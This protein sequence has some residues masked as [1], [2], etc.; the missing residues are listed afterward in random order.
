MTTETFHTVDADSPPAPAYDRSVSMARANVLALLVIPVVAAFVLVPFALLHGTGALGGAWN[1][2][3]APWMFIPFVLISIVVHE[4]LHGVGFLAAGAP[5]SSLKFGVQVRTL[6]PYASCT[7]P[8]PVRR[9]RFAAALPALG[10]GVLPML[11]SWVT[12]SADLAWV[13]AWM[14]AF[15]GGDLLILWLIRDLPPET[16]VIDHPERAGCRIVPA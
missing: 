6:T 13:A 8:L 11:A 12:G 2:I 4:G 15:A 1:R 9:Y 3:T 16:Q 7:V 5:R 10:L 14:L